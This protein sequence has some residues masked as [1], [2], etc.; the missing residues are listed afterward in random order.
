MRTYFKRLSNH[1]GV[2]VASIL[3]VAFTFSGAATERGAA[4]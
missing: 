2:P 4:P 3:T 1:P